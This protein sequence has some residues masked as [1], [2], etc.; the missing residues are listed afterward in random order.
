MVS[1]TV[2]VV[3]GSY[4]KTVWLIFQYSATTMYPNVPKFGVL[5]INTVLR[6][7]FH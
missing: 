2:F 1:I 3:F 4:D 6:G 7:R 5:M